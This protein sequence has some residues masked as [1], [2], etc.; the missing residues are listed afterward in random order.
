MIKLQMKEEAVMAELNQLI[1]WLRDKQNPQLCSL[2]LIYHWK[3]SQQKPESVEFKLIMTE[4]AI[5]KM[6]DYLI[7]HQF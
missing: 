2:F 7:N 4:E 3:H 6:T 5:I 1:R